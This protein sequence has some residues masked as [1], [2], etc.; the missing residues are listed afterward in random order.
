MAL[1]SMSTGSKAW[2]PRRWRGGARFRRTGRVLVTSSSTSHTS[3]RARSTMRLALLMLWAIPLDTRACMTKGLKSSRAMRLGRPHWCSCNSGP[4]TAAVVDEGVHGLLEHALLVADDDLGRPQLQEPL[5]AIV[6][7]DDAPVQVVQVAGGEAAAVQ[8]DHGAQVRRQGGQ[9]GEDHP[10]RLVAALAE[11]LHHPQPLGGLLATL[12]AGGMDLLV[13]P[14]AC[15][16]DVQALEY[17][18][19]GLRILQRLDIERA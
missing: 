14:G 5:Q 18:E 4:T 7:V 8:L 17:A 13:E 6:A 11:G 19:D 2:M 12:A 10:L 16:L 9:H 15:S 1:P 3:G